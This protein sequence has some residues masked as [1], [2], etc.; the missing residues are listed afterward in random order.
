LNGPIEKSNLRSLYYEVRENLATIHPGEN[1]FAQ[2]HLPFNKTNADLLDSL[3]FTKLVMLRDP[4]AI[5][6]SFMFHVLNTEHPLKSYF[7]S[8]PD[9]DTRLLA[10]IQGVTPTQTGQANIF[11]SDVGLRFRTIA[12]WLQLPNTHEIRFENLIGPR[13]NGSKTSQITS[14]EKLARF[15]N[16]PLSP[17]QL[18]AIAGRVFDTTSETFRAGQINGWRKYFKP[19]HAQA[20]K[21]T[22]NDVLIEFGYE[23]GSNWPFIA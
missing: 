19:C 23:V 9:N 14:L 3:G 1:K 21:K 10:S 5:A 22:A 20:F 16:I 4:R 12:N 6:V 8:L 17:R 18:E 2:G 13:G 15:L 7:L 11:L